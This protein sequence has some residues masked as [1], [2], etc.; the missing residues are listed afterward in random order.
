MS[1]LQSNIAINTILGK[2]GSII[3]TAGG[4]ATGSFSALYA[5][6][7][8]TV[9]SDLTSSTLSFATGATLV[10]TTFP[11]NSILYGDFTKFRLGSGSVI[12]YTSGLPDSYSA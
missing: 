9:F 4:Q 1:V 2:Y 3:V 7:A 6:A 12:A 11:A 8:N 10:G 5:L